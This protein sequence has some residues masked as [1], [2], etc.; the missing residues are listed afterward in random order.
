MSNKKISIIVPVYNEEKIIED[1]LDAL[2]V[3]DYLK[4]DYEI[5]VVNDGSTDATLKAIKRKQKEAERKDVV[6][7]IINLEKNKGWIISREA[8]AKNAKY[9]NLLFI[10]SRCAAIKEVLKNIKKINYQPIVGNPLVNFRKS[11]LARFNLLFRKKLYPHYFGENFEPVFITEDNFDSIPKGT[12]I[13]FCDKNLF[14]SSQPS[15]L[16]IKKKLVSDDIKLLWNIVQ[17]TKILK[18]PDVKIVYSPRTS[19]QEEIK[20]TFERGPRFVDYYSNPKKKR[21]W[22]FIFLP[23]F[24]LSFTIVLFLISLTKFLHWL[25]FLA[26]LWILVS[27]WS[28]ENIKD[29]F[30]VMAY[31]PI[32][33]FSFELGILKGLLFKLFKKY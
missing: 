22:F 6:I 17:Q 21:F 28:A 20:H 25:G 31:L 16:R 32:I 2:I 1:C 5:V 23:L 14:L 8:G 29:F 11:N 30:I 27:I 4:S 3:Q 7:R 9:D 10:D 13:F 12:T 18:H 24:I 15:Q 33:G 26:I 19:L